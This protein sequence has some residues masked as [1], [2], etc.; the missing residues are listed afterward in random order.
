MQAAEM[1]EYLAH[2]WSAMSLS[3]NTSGLQC[4]EHCNKQWDNVQ[5]LT[6]T[7]RYGI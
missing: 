5:F 7:A 2:L 4:F 3:L 1:H 6:A